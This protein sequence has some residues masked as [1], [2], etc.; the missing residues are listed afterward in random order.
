MLRII[1]L[2]VPFFLSGS[3]INL[4]P[5]EQKIFSQNGEDGIIHKIF[6]CIGIETGYY[7]EFGVESG[8]ECNTRAL[9]EIHGWHGLMMDG[10]NQNAEI[11]LQKEFITAENINQLFS[12]HSVPKR[13]DLL[14]IDIDYNDFYV[15]NAISHKYNPRVVVI[16]YNATH[17]PHEDKVSVYNP[18]HMWDQTNYFGASILALKRLGNKK[19]YTL[20]Y[21]DNM[22]VNLFFIK[23]SILKKFNVHFTNE[24]NEILLYK[25]PSYGSG[26][27]S[28]HQQDPQNRPYISSEQARRQLMAR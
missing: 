26:P 24:D 22:G 17:L 15:W 4:E 5:F 18:T 8:T 28:G 14:S 13:F 11:N 6:E 25:P 1:F 3:T 19:G 7:V 20:V 27:N 10:S 12:K 2:F 16:E 23:S 9:R 21:A